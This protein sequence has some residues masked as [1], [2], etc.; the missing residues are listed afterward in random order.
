[1]HVNTK[2]PSLLP[3]CIKHCSLLVLS[4]HSKVAST[5]IYM[6]HI[7]C[8]YLPTY[9]PIYLP[10]YLPTPSCTFLPTYLHLPMYLPTYLP[11]YVQYL[12]TYLPTNVPCIFFTRGMFENA[13]PVSS[14]D[15][16]SESTYKHTHL[17]N[18]L[19]TALIKCI[20]YAKFYANGTSAYLPTYLSVCLSTSVFLSIYLSIHNIYPSLIPS[21]V[22]YLCMSNIITCLV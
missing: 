4:P 22:S 5:C 7:Y 12:P 1:M 18:I 15:T 17:L 20:K 13:S 14:L 3:T 19:R 6:Y 9:L 10:T 16:S 8:T 11:T 2:S 21:C